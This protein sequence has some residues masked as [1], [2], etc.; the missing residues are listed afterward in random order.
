MV[1]PS[2]EGLRDYD[3]R[4]IHDN[5]MFQAS[6]RWIPG[7]F[8]DLL[9]RPSTSRILMDAFK[10]ESFNAALLAGFNGKSGYV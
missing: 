10:S 5:P 9:V 7:C 4:I 8:T 2:L 6:S 3:G 1:F